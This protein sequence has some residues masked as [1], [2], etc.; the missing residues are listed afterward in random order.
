MRLYTPD[1]L[2]YP[3]TVTKLLRQPGDDIEQNAALFT[4][5]YKSAVQEWDADKREDAE[6]LES[7]YANFES[8][9]EGSITS[10]DVKKGQVITGRTSVADIEEPCKHEIQFGGI[11]ANCGKDMTTVQYNSTTKNTDRATVNTVHGHTQL[12]VSQEQAS[13]AD[14]EAKRRLLDSQKLSLVV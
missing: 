7:F 3:I 10:L 4:Y 11:C 13:L 2:L 12:L 5:E 6:N 1:S 8:E 14:E 9:L